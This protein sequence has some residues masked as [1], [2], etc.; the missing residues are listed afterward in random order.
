MVH[1]PLEQKSVPVQWR[2]E[3]KEKLRGFKTEQNNN[4]NN[5]ENVINCKDF[6]YLENKHI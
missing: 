5:N 4:N 2:K 1:L 3:N 6:L